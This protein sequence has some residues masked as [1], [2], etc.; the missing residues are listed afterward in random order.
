MKQEYQLLYHDML[1]DIERCMQLELPNEERIEACFWV[2]SNYWEKLK[3]LL[4]GREFKDDSDEIE[5]FRN[6]KPRF[7]C[8]IEYFILLSEALVFVPE[9][10]KCAIAFWEEESRR[11]NRFCTRNQ[12]FVSYYESGKRSKDNI[13]FLRKNADDLSFVLSAPVYD[14]DVAFCSSRDQIVRR[15]LAYKMFNEYAKKRL[16]GLERETGDVNRELGAPAATE[17]ADNYQSNKR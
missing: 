8:Y 9:D 7:T 2:A 13:Y 5:F 4:E 10:K 3:E 1:A 12:I 6:V 17:Q 16:D 14:V 11:F 15:Y